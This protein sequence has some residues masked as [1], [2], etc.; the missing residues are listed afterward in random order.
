VLGFRGTPATGP[1][2]AFDVELATHRSR[3]RSIHQRVWFR[4]LL[5]SLSGAGPLGEVATAEP[6]AEEPPAAEP[7]A[8]EPGSELD[9]PAE[10]TA[11]APGPADG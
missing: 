8:E 6:Q 9:A 4:P 11:D 2:E 1:T 5:A 7:P 10:A 3:V